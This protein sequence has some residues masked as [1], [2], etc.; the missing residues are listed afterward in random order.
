MTRN[1]RMMKVISFP[2]GIHY[3]KTQDNKVMNQLVAKIF[4]ILPQSLSLSCSEI[5]TLNTQNRD[6]LFTKNQ[7]A[8]AS[9]I[10]TF[11]N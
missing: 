2:M 10:L 8:I 4:K 3:G 9:S 6:R 1:L 5:A 7:T 11:I